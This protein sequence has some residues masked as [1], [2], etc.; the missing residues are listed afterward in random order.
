MPSTIS[1]EAQ[2]WLASL[3]QSTPGP[4]ALPERRKRTDEW[5]AKQSAEALRLFPAKVEST[6][7]AGVPTDILTPLE[8][9]V[10]NR[11]RVL[12]NLH[13]GGFNSGED[14]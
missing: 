3:T 1:P 6:K 9:P 13:G 12:I 14:V 7:T 10:A 5:R 4:E 2:K 8:N 11:D